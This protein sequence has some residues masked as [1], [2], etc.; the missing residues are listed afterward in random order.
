MGGVDTRLSGEL[1]GRGVQPLTTLAALRSGMVGGQSPHLPHMATKVPAGTTPASRV[2][3]FPRGLD[4]AHILAA[5]YF[6]P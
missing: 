3:R 6:F 5:G 1:H 4:K 2:T